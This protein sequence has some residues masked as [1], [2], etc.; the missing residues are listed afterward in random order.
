M[1]ILLPTTCF[2]HSCEELHGTGA[3]SESKT[4]AVLFEICR[5]HRTELNNIGWNQRSTGGMAK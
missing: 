4:S 3:L 5:S 1:R 2:V